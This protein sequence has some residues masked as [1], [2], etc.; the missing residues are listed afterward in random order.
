MHAGVVEGRVIVIGK[1]SPDP[2][3]PAK[4]SVVGLDPLDACLHPLK[5]RQGRG[6]EK[7]RKSQANMYAPGHFQVNFYCLG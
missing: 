7:V 5:E 3:E 2:K 4:Y 6:V 1:N